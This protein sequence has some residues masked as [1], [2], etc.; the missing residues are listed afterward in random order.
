M[1]QFNYQREAYKGPPPSYHDQPYHSQTWQTAASKPTSSH[2][3]QFSTLPQPVA[4]PQIGPGMGVPF[5]RAYS[6]YLEALG[7]SISEFMDFIDHLNV[8]ATASPPLQVLNLAGGIIGAVPHHWAAVA[9]NVLSISAQ[10]GTAAVSKGRTELYLRDMNARLFNPRGL[11][12]NLATTEAM[13]VKCKIPVGIDLLEGDQT[14]TFQER[15]LASVA[16]FCAPITLAVPPPATED[17]AL[18][19]LSA[20]QVDRNVKSMDKKRAKGREK[21]E[22]KKEKHRQEIDSEMAKLDEEIESLEAH[23]NRDLERKPRDARKLERERDKVEKKREKLEEK[24]DKPSKA[25]AK[26]EKQT[27]KVLWILIENIERRAA[28]DGW[29]G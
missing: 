12:V 1:D 5:A 8:V 24:L 21:D 4:I 6:P 22:K 9:G 27:K 17:S 10:L 26:E 16:K 13:M 18:D 28:V 11:Q 7:I 15:L 25:H 2:R 23:M 20:R 19:K 29:H 14:R 3:S